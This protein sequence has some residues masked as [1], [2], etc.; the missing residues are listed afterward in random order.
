[1]IMII[2]PPAAAAQAAALARSAAER[3]GRGEPCHGSV[4]VQAQ[5]AGWS[6][7]RWTVTH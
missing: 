1:M 4:K 2:G 6:L 7:G 5:N 3:A